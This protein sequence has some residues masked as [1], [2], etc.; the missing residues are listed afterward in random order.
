MA[1][2]E[3]AGTAGAGDAGDQ[4]GDERPG[5]QA[6][7]AGTTDA[8]D[9]FIDPATLPPELKAHW[10]RM[11]G[12][13]NRRLG[14]LKARQA[15]LDLV[16]RYRSDP[17]FA[18]AFLAEEAARLGVK[19]TPPPAAAPAA[20]A[21]LVEAV[22]A[23]LPAELQWM[24]PGIAASTWVAQQKALSPLLQQT[25]QREVSQRETEYDDLAAELTEA[26]PG[27]EQHEDDMVDLLEFLESSRM[28][29]RRWGSKLELLHRLV[30]G[31]ARATVG[32]IRRIGDAARAR[33]VTGQ[34]GRS[35]GPNIAD[36]VRQARTNTEAW[37][38]AGQ[39]AI[40]EAKK[41]GL[42]IE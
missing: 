11:H 20:P 3:Q 27:W 42:A 30:T 13:Y 37:E 35:T 22:R 23:Q 25:Q 1:D 12:A 6:A 24:A 18:R 21:E 26:A 19:P 5:T 34:S 39:Y 15:D 8:E 9:S 36:R 40:E 29:D 41:H 33:S 16:D 14:E 38:L 10:K 32:A 7:A 31:D 2:L 17:E 28:R 4:G